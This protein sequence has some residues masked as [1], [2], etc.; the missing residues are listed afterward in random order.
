VKGMVA[1]TKINWYFPFLVPNCKSVNAMINR[2]NLDMSFNLLTTTE[3][4]L[5][6]AF[7]KD[8]A[9]YLGESRNQY[10]KSM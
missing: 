1:P 10:S 6:T 9:Q 8:A 7:Q 4:Y 2:T 3:T 5:N